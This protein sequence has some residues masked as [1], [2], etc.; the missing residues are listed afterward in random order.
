MP[1]GG[2]GFYYFT[3]YV[4]VEAG[5]YGHFEIELNDT[6]LC[7]AFSEVQQTSQDDGPTSCS[8]VTYARE[9]W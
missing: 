5:K 1:P 8:A 7:T 3:T 9:S 6:L 4:L 2:D